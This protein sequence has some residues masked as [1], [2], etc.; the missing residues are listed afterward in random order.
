MEIYTRSYG[1][2]D[3]E[4]LGSGKRWEGRG[5]GVI[6]WN[7]SGSIIGALKSDM[8]P[9]AAGI[10]LDIPLCVMATCYWVRGGLLI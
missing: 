4:S 8:A 6:R 7:S 2:R 5:V 10:T 1:R 3:T 9:L